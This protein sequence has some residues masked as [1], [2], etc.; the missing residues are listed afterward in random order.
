MDFWYTNSSQPGDGSINFSQ[1]ANITK[2]V[3]VSLNFSPQVNINRNYSYFLHRL[4]YD[5]IYWFDGHGG[6]IVNSY[7]ETFY[8]ISSQNI[9]NT[10][11]FSHIINSSSLE[12]NLTAKLV[13]I[14]AC[15]SGD[16]ATSF[17]GCPL[18]KWLSKAFTD[19]GAQCYLGFLGT[20]A[21]ESCSDCYHCGGDLPID[22]A[23]TFN[24]CFWG[25]ISEGKS[26]LVSMTDCNNENVH[27]I[28][29]NK[30]ISSCN[31]TLVGGY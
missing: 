25:K 3:L 11:V 16:N 18:Q 19:Y 1:S 8:A 20:N 12:K 23:T 26:I 29:V 24:Q 15:D 5:K 2:S 7:N 28:L 31:K 21:Q 14:T 4:P 27:A 30:T 9:E 10:A 13:M 17:S 22:A 6:I